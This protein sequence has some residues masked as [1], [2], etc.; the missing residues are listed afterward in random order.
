M[1]R[2]QLEKF[3]EEEVAK[4]AAE[5]LREPVKQVPVAPV[6]KRPDPVLKNEEDVDNYLFRAG[7][8]KDELGKIIKK[9][10]E[11]QRRK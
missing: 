4:V 10:Y 1:T 2:K 7:M 11:Q 5:P 6:M 3:I 9:I 8:K